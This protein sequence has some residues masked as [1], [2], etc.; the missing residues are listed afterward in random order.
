MRMAKKAQAFILIMLLLCVVVQGQSLQ[1]QAQEVQ[2]SKAVEENLHKKTRILRLCGTHNTRDLGG[3]E[4]EDAERTRY[5]VIFRSDSTHKSGDTDVKVLQARGVTDVIDLRSPRSVEK[6]GDKF[7]NLEGVNYHNLYF[8]LPSGDLGPAYAEMLTANK[9]IV[10]EIFEVLV[11]AKGAVLIHC[12]IGKD[13]TGVACA[14]ILGALGC[15]REEILRDYT[16]SRK[17]LL[18]GREESNPPKAT[19][20]SLPEYLTPMLEYIDENFDSSIERYVLEAC[21]VC[22]KILL[23]LRNKML[24]PN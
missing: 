20:L 23:A 3:Y 22:P 6:Y 9:D 7:I 21:G 10:P 13:R 5:G 8:P 18:H 19:S 14:L 2:V 16:P 11:N 24:I 17:L 1:A 12:Q 15:T 4:T